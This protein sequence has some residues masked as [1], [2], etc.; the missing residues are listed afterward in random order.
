MEVSKL[1]R[2]MSLGSAK[3]KGKL[4]WYLLLMLLEERNNAAAYDIS[5]EEFFRLRLFY[6]QIAGVSKEF[7][8]LTVSRIL[9][10]KMDQR[11]ILVG[12]VKSSMV[13]VLLLLMRARDR[14]TKSTCRKKIGRNSKIDRPRD[15]EEDTHQRFFCLA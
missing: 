9:D 7:G 12:L 1:A 10:L 4:S 2:P 14:G 13:R 15:E 11:L 3:G 5:S 6:R 8:Q